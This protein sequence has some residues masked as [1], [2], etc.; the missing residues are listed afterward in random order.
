MA[1]INVRDRNKNKDGIKAS[2]EYYFEIAQ[3]DGKR[4]KISKSGFLTKKEAQVAGTKALSEYNNTGKAFV[5]SEISVSDLFDYWLNNYAEPR[6]AYATI[7]AYSNIIK[8][9][10]KPRIGFYRLKNIDT[11]AIQGMINDI[12]LNHDFSKAFTKSILK[13]TKSVFHYAKAF[14]KFINI[15]PSADVELPTRF[16][17]MELVNE[18][19]KE[20]VEKI[21]QRFKTSPHHYYALLIAYYTG[22]RVSEVYGLTWDCI[23]FENNTLTVDKCAKEID[24]DC[25]GMRHGGFKRRASEKWYLGECKTL[26]SY[27]T[28][29]MSKTLAQALKD[30]KQIQENNRKK[31]GDLYLENYLQE[32]KTSSGRQVFQIIPLS[33]GVANSLCVALPKANLVIVKDNGTFQGTCAM[34]YCSKIINLEM[35][36]PFRFHAFRHTHATVLYEN[37][38]PIKDIQER[39]GHSNISTTMNIY[40]SNTTKNQDKTMEIFDKTGS[41]EMDLAPRNEKLYSL[42]KTLINRCKTTQ[43]YVSKGIKVCNE[44]EDFEPFKNWAFENGFDSELQLIRIDLSQGYNPDNCKWVTPHE[45]KAVKS[46]LIA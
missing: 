30:Y 23:D 18:I 26:S 21:L 11:P 41:L 13:V 25:A 8:N 38:A 10:I 2:W 4:K 16:K 15:D 28:I 39:L 33:I 40:V 42:W 6:L 35:G 20:D 31:F 24:V 32:C 7:A 17:H 3:I 27:R 34:R 44:W 29:K 46:R 45:A 36:I 5:P 12:H 22:L 14:A 1:K 19:K 37:G 9:H 43:S